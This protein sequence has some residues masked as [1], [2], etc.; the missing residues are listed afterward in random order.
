M[1]DIPAARAQYKLYLVKGR[2][3]LS[4]RIDHEDIDTAKMLSP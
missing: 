3:N 2:Q 4:N 1:V